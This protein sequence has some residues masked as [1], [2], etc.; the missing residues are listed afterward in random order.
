VN[1][2][3]VLLLAGTLVKYGP[4]ND[5]STQFRGLAEKGEFPTI[6]YSV[7][8]LENGTLKLRLV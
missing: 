5:G 8:T 4:I 7:S 2:D 1:K 3:F 6:F